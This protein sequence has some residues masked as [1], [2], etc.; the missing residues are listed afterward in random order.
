ME[1]LGSHILFGDDD[2]VDLQ[3]AV[4][5]LV[6]YSGSVW[7]HIISLKRKD[8]ARLGYDRESAWRDLLRAER[9][10]IAAAM[11]IPVDNF[12]WHAAVHDEGA[13]PHVHMMAWSHQLGFSSQWKG[14]F[15]NLA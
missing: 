2:S 14:I 6:C 9:S 7:T 12:C 13:Y 11:S 15:L 1:Q 5:E 10:K 4:S 8:V 3:K